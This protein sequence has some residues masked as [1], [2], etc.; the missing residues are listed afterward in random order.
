MA[1]PETPAPTPTHSTAR[2]SVTV[3]TTLP[4]QPF[5]ANAARTPIRTANLVL[6]ALTQG[7]LGALH[8]LRTQRAV[9][10]R[11]VA[12]RPDRDVAETQARLDPFLAH[13]QG[14]ERTFNPGVCLASTGELIGLGGVFRAVADGGGN[15]NGGL[16]WPEVGYMF[17]EEHWGKGYATEFLQAFLKA[18]WALPRVEARITVDALSVAGL[19]GGEGEREREV[20]GEGEIEVRER[21]CAIVEETNVGSLR[22]ME[23]T[24]FK[25][26]KTWTEVSQR[27][28]E[29]GTEITVAGFVIVRPEV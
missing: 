16:G 5:P 29:E 11:T 8:A 1:A 10:A 3:K 28:G 23:K 19:E 25:R 21:L 6:R 27:P 14:D 2:A 18:W 13:T 22:V 20:E 15:G 26:F 7:D 4:A 12:G 9:M 24:G 17:R